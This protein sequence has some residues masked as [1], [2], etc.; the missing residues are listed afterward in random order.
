[1]GIFTRNKTVT[2]A[3]AVLLLTAL[4]ACSSKEVVVVYSPHGS[5][6]L[7]DWEARFE[8]AHPEV[9]MQWFDMGSKEV[10]GRIRAEQGRPQADVWW[11]APSTFFSQAAKED[12][13]EP[14]TPEWAAALD[15][16]YKD[17]EGRWHATYLSPLAVMFNTRKYQ[18][19]EVP[20][21]WDDLL[22]VEW[23]GKLTFRKPLPSG[24]MRTFI[25]AMVMGAESEDAGI[26]WLTRLHAGTKDYPES[27]ALLYDH[28]KR[29]PELVSVWLQPD[30]V[31]Q[32]D[33]NGYPFGYH[34]PPNTPVLTDA[35]ALVKN[36]PHPKWA[37]VF[38]DFV[39]TEEALLQQ[40]DAYAK[41]PARD[42]IAKE[43]LPEW[44]RGLDIDAMK[45]DWGAFA[46]QEA[47]ICKRWDQEVYGS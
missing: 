3:A 20:Q 30:I 7:R 29:N 38:Y 8:A 16:A 11:G 44:M 17:P 14:Y 5:E 40:A 35:I 43:K 18:P 1:M 41:L 42:D 34:I 45:I 24:T 10:Y 6:V 36:A 26:A 25:T 27:P 39:T 21:T 22:N 46:E 15:P 32:R 47:H 28:I 19:E 4:S 31:M 9:D 2:T 33:R 13:L 23:S 37:K 12:L